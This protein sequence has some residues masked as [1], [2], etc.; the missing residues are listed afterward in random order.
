MSS[1]ILL[2]GAVGFTGQ[3]L[4][5]MAESRGHH[6]L[7]LQSDLND[8]QGMEDELNGQRIEKVVHLAGI[9]FVGHADETAFYKVNVIGTVNLLKALKSQQKHLTSVLIASSANVYGNCDASPI[10]ENQP[11]A[12]V[13]H[14]AMSKLAMEH[15]ARTCSDSLPLLL[16]RP[17]NY[18]GPG[19]APGFLIPKLVDHFAR[20]IPQIEL[21]NLHV[22]REFNDVRMVCDAYLALLDKGVPGEVYNV[23]SGQPYT[24]QAVITALEEL[25]GHHMQ[26][27]VNPAFVRAN[28]VHRLC[29]N[30]DKL[31]ACTGPLPAYT[32]KDTLSSML[33]DARAS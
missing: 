3:H 9:S 25:T 6:V 7:A 22:E 24:L 28:E 10:S 30:P 19:Q 11:P 8:V 13:N 32:L 31:R 26:V 20:R 2:T 12:P 21:G 29:G 5:K 14:Y 4:K 1:C 27:N 23:C 16:T 17:F 15:M 18:T 33:A